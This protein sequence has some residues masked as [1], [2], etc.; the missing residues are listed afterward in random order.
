[1]SKQFCKG[2]GIKLK[3]ANGFVSFIGEKVYG[4][5]PNDDLTPVEFND[6]LFCLVCSKK[7][8]GGKQ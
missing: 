2:C 8:R 5:K 4:D 1:M 7:R 3:N 6:G